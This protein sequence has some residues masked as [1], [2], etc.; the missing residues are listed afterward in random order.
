MVEGCV[1]AF[2]VLFKLLLSPFIIVILRAF[3]GQNSLDLGL[4]ILDLKWSYFGLAHLFLTALRRRV[5]S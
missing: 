2:L 3:L 4:Q 1:E 5:K